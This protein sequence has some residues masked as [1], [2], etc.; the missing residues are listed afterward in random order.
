MKKILYYVIFLLVILFSVESCY[1][2]D[3][4]QFQLNLPD[5]VS[6]TQNIQPI[7]TQYC[8]TTSCHEGTSKPDLRVGIAYN[9]L[10]KGGYISSTFPERGILYQSISSNEMPP[11]GSL[12]P[13][14]K[15][16]I[17]KWLEDGG[18]NN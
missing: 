1:Y 14:D 12:S 7:F 13:V 9:E 15:A 3:P 16:L 8:S 6:F 10:I 11:D 4:P 17:F 5:K 18:D 2:D